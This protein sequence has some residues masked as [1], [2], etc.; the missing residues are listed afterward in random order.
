MYIYIYQ[1]VF[2][3]FLL[4]FMFSLPDFQNVRLDAVESVLFI[5]YLFLFY[6]CFI[7][8]YLY[9]YRISSNKRPWRL[10]YFEIVKCGAY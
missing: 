8:I 5:F 9:I 2:F 1:I 10:L 4:Y 7:K 3:N 6:F